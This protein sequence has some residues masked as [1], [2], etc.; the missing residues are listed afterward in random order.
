MM[1]GHTLK[2]GTSSRLY[3]FDG[4]QELMPAEGLNKEQRRQLRALEFSR[5]MQEKDAEVGWVLAC[6]RCLLALVWHLT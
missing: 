5:K 6:L 2:F 1:V 3:L 4:P